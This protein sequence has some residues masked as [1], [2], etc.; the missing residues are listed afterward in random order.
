MV[1]CLQCYLYGEPGIGKTSLAHAIAGTSNLP[2][3]ALNATVSGKKDIEDV[4][5]KHESQAKFY[6]FLMKFIVL[7]NYNKI[8]CFPMLK[9]DPSF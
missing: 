4:V 5:Q 8:H 9:M 7:I 3:I 1:M 6:Y 2:F